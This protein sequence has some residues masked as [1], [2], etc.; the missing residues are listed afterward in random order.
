MDTHRAFDRVEPGREVRTGD[1]A[2]F[3]ARQDLAIADIQD[4]G[5]GADPALARRIDDKVQI[6]RSIDRPQRRQ[7]PA[8]GQHTGRG[9]L[10]EARLEQQRLQIGTGLQ[11]QLDRC[12]TGGGR[13][14]ALDLGQDARFVALEAH[15]GII[16]QPGDAAL[17]I[18]DPHGG[19]FDTHMLQPAE[20]AGRV[21]RVG[22][23]LEEAG[24]FIAAPLG[25]LRIGGDA[26]G[27]AQPG[28][29]SA[30]GPADERERT[31]LDVQS[32]R[33]QPAEQQ[34]V[35]RETGLNAR[36][37]GD[38]IAGRVGNR[39]IAGHQHEGAR[40]RI[41]AGLQPAERHDIAL[42]GLRQHALGIL[43]QEVEFNRTAG[44]TPQDRGNAEDRQRQ[45]HGDRLEQIDQA[46]AQGLAQ[47]Q[48]LPTA[49]GRLDAPD[50]TRILHSS[51][52]IHGNK[53]KRDMMSELKTGD[54]APT[55]KLPADGGN[56]IDLADLRGKTVVLYFYP[57]D[58][59]PGCTTEAIDFTHAQADFEAA[60]TVVIGVSKDSVQKHDKFKAKHDLS[61]ALVADEA[62]EICEAY[63][64]WVLKK[65]YGRE[66]MGI[67]RATFLIGPDGKI[68]GIWRKVKVKGHADVVLEAARK[69]A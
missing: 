56:E 38:H 54:L 45:Q 69:L 44:Q 68:A 3:A 40:L 10:L 36:R 11:A 12:K 37:P 13:E 64:V 31:A 66:Y 48:R 61:V 47:H 22:Q 62:G 9:Q 50:S 28:P 67:E 5:G 33:L 15:T 55:F 35:D 51:A 19:L 57:K 46:P 32:D 43:A 23:E 60:N 30:I 4:D 39:H 25:Q 14:L 17:G 63:G 7:R 26:L 52:R 49:A 41:E 8:V 42:E 53:R 1:P 24:T 16:H 20:A 27:T 2:G 29:D 21:L 59:T 65:L 58:D 18:D 34:C 6:D